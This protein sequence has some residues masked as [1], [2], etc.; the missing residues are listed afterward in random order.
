MGDPTHVLTSATVA[1]S[2]PVTSNGLYPWYGDYNNK[3]SD[4]HTGMP[5]VT[6][7][8]PANNMTAFVDP[9][10]ATPLPF[11]FSNTNGGNGRGLQPA[12][13]PTDGRSS[14]IS[15]YN[16]GSSRTPTPAK[17]TNAAANR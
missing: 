10:N 8:N 11:S 16:T 4:T 13:N 14:N 6:S 17:N 12:G 5:F 15:F 7:S 1:P 9:I 2:N 3:F